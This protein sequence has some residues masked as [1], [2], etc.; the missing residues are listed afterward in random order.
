MFNATCDVQLEMC[1]SC[2]L[3]ITMLI[4]SDR[5]TQRRLESSPTVWQLWLIWQNLHLCFASIKGTVLNVCT[6]LIA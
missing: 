4:L 2:R 1:I 5:E 3:H 6:N